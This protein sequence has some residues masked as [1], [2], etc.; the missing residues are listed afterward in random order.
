MHLLFMHGF[1]TLIFISMFLSSYGSNMRSYKKNMI[2]RFD[3]VLIWVASLMPPRWVLSHVMLHLFFSHAFFWW[4]M[5]SFVEKFEQYQQTSGLNWGRTKEMSVCFE[6]EGF[7]HIWTKKGWYVWIIWLLELR[8]L[9]CVS[10]F[11]L[12]CDR[13]CSYTSGMCFAVWLGEVPPGQ[14]FVTSKNWW[15]VSVIHGKMLFVCFNYWHLW[16]DFVQIEKTN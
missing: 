14:C 7:Y 3:N 11:C 4:E 1:T 2:P 8:L 5:V 6:R 10:M 15:V 9:S 16:S 13:K 12:M